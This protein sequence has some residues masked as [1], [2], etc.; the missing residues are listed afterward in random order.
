[1]K[2][3]IMTTALMLGL[4]VAGPV[5]ALTVDQLVALGLSQSE[6]AIVAGLLGDD[7]PA[8]TTG[9]FVYAGGLIKKSTSYSQQAY[10]LQT[11]LVELGVNSP[12]NVDGYFG[13]LT[14]AAVEA[15]QVKNGLQKDGI[16]GPETGPVYTE[17]CAGAEVVVE[18][19]ESTPSEDI[20][21]RFDSQDGD[22]VDFDRYDVEDAD[23][24]QIE[25]GEKKAEIAEIE[26]D[27]EDEGAALLER[28]DFMFTFTGTDDGDE[29]EPWDVFE[30]IYLIHDGDVIGEVEADDEDEY[31]DREIDLAASS[32]DE[33]RLRMSGI[34]FVLEA[35]EDYTFE[36][37]ADITGSIDLGTDKQSEWTLTLDERSLRF[38]DEAGITVYLGEEVDGSTESDVEFTIEEEGQEDE[39]TVRESDNDPES[40]AL[41]VED[42]ETSEF[43]NIFTF[44]ID[45]D[46]DSQDLEFD[47][48]FVTV[49][50]GTANVED[51][52][53]DFELK[54]G[55]TV[56]DD[57]KFETGA[58]STTAVISFDVED[59]DFIIDADEKMDVELHAEFNSANG[60]NYTQGETV[61]ASVTGAN[62]DAWDV[63]GGED[64]DASQL[65]GA[66][67][68]EQHTLLVDGAVVTLDG[69]SE[70]AIDSSDTAVNDVLSATFEIDVEAFDETVY[71]P[72]VGTN[73][74]A[75][76]VIDAATNSAVAGIDTLTLSSSADE[77]TGADGNDYYRVSS[78]ESFEVKITDNEAAGD[79]Y[80]ELT[81]LNFTSEDVTA[82]GFV[83]AATAIVLDED[84]FKSGTVTLLN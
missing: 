74:L 10:D 83:F 52:V 22:E 35:D 23:D 15:F 64:L 11:C 19:S 12:A 21:D 53:D 70:E 9:S 57:W 54:M 31:E 7:A 76:S 50:T 77:V 18:P 48:I 41:E 37:A 2:K 66:A 8:S 6:A 49:E 25:E 60:T 44:E 68:G 16:V 17:A 34:N 45:V 80:A 5:G 63:D 65:K 69:V 47:E 56:F 28:A 71:I 72:V 14:H 30:T 59:E 38:V 73:A 40:T 29:L 79:Y 4:A 24:D 32:D 51:V 36:V 78:T 82:G 84:E 46:E 42:D 75:A 67:V 13:N 26:I 43:F 1:M 33:N 20:N 58:A 39:L 55:S 61:T 27:L 81:G 62:V 3:F